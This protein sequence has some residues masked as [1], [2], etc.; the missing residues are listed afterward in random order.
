MRVIVAGGRTFP[1]IGF[2]FQ[3]LDEFHAQSPITT[4]IHG[5]ARGVD[6]IA[7]E[8][9]KSR[10][11]V[12]PVVYP[13]KWNTHKSAKWNTHKLAAGPIRNQ[14]MIDEGTPDVVILFPGNKG[15]RD[16]ER[17]AKASGIP[18]IRYTMTTN[19]ESMI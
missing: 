17:K 5:G 2:V 3:K 13:A 7:G 12:D 19:I 8:W 18:V 11:G 14:Q 6:T 4:V 9:C 1:Y 15:T 16:M 10:L